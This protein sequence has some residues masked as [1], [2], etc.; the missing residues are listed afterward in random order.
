MAA[1]T[2]RIFLA[3]LAVANALHLE[4]CTGARMGRG[5]HR[6]DAVR[7]IDDSLVWWWRY[8][9]PQVFHYL[10][11]PA[12]NPIIMKHL[13]NDTQ[14]LCVVQFLLRDVEEVSRIQSIYPDIPRLGV[15]RQP[16]VQS[17]IPTGPL[18]DEHMTPRGEK[19][20][21]DQ[22]SSNSSTPSIWSNS[23]RRPPPPVSSQPSRRKRLRNGPSISLSV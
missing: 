18:P 5:L 10:R 13:Y 1:A 23:V 20:P 3:T 12:T 17:N 7:D 11:T 15:Q 19:R 4:G 9:A 22:L 8:T 21:H 14:D 2:R 6:L 16:D